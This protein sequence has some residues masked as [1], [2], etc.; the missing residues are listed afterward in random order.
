[1]IFPIKV[2]YKFCI[3][4]FWGLVC[5]NQFLCIESMSYF[6]AWEASVRAQEGFTP[7]EVNLMFL[8]KESRDGIMR[9]GK[10][11]YMWCI[12]LHSYAI[13]QFVLLWSLWK[14]FL[15]YQG[16]YAFWAIEFARTPLKSILVCKGS[17]ELPMITLPSHAAF[18]EEHVVRGLAWKLLQE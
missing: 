18:S 15:K 3:C 1:M 16:L 14:Q 2:S 13:L 8:S 12:C 5:F 10:W 7:K 4:T 9:S 11:F 17:A 6:E